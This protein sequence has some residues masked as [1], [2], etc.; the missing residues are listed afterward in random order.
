MD[1]LTYLTYCGYQRHDE[2]T[3]V[4]VDVV[5]VVV[6]DKQCTI[7]F[8]QMTYQYSDGLESVLLLLFKLLV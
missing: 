6:H 3:L 7:D 5:V 4:V 1:H 8:G 2:E